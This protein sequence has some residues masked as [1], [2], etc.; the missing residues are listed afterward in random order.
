MLGSMKLILEMFVV[1]ALTGCATSAIQ[2]QK[3]LKTDHDIAA[4]QLIREVPFVNQE[5]GQCGPAT[6]TMA[7]NWAGHPVTV[8][9]ILPQ[10]YNPKMKGSLQNDMISSSR[11]NGLMAIPITGLEPLL[12]EVNAGHPVIVFEN[13][14]LSWLPQWHYAVVIGYDLPQQKVIM[15]SGPEAFK[16]WD[17]EKFE[18]S[19]MLGDYWGL[20]ILP[21][22]QLSKTADEVAHITSASALEQVGQFKAAEIAYQTILK[23]WPQSLGALIGM[24]NIS[25]ENKDYNKAVQYLTEATMFHPD[26]AFAWHNLAVAQGNAH[27]KKQ[28]KQ[29]A[30][31]ALKLASTENYKAFEENLSEWIKQ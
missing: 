11:R 22:D 24:G 17:M 20:V 16:Y 3:F 25:F 14:A 21:P 2:T 6:L 26:S 9:E 5:A 27:L 23:K 13:L 10:V 8:Q 1:V 12:T 7:M 31:K 29:S 4:T 30:V 15:H 18:R 28:A 19:W